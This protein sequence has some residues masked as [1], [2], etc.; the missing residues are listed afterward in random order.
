MQEPPRALRKP[1]PAD[2]RQLVIEEKQV[3]KEADYR[4]LV[5]AESVGCFLHQELKFFF[6]TAVNYQGVNQAELNSLKHTARL[7]LANGN[8]RY[9]RWICLR[10]TRRR[11]SST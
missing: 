2:V 11:T 8:D 4:P 6:E 9:T 3:F 5:C 1:E 10:I 7:V